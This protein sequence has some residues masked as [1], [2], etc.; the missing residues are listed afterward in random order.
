[1]DEQQVTV[2]EAARQETIA[3][4][5]LGVVV[6]PVTLRDARRFIAEHHRHNVAPRGWLFG[7]RLV[8]EGVTVG[9]GV[10]S[11]PVARGLDDG[12]MVEITRLCLVSGAPKNAASR[13]YGALC[14]AAAALGYTRAVTYTLVSEA[15]TSVR[16]SGFE[17][18][19][20][21]PARETWTPAEGVQRA[22]V[23]IFGETRRPQEAKVRWE[24]ALR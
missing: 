23:D 6:M 5:C 16:A 1:M 2:V 14:R 8:A 18:I 19:A 13:L 3:S 20:Q 21:L 10:A 7:A 4:A 9:V 12:R 17:P 11:R 15:G 22:Q 24:R